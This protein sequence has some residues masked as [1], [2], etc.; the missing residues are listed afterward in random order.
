MIEADPTLLE[1]NL[2]SLRAKDPELALRIAM[3]AADPSVRAERARDGSVVPFAQSGKRQVY[4]NS[5]YEPRKEAERL[6]LERSG[7]GY[8]VCLGLGGGYQARAILENR[9]TSGVLIVETSLALLKA[10]LERIDIRDILSDG[11]VSVMAEA[12]AEECALKLSD[13]YLPVLSG[14]LRTLPL[15][16]RIDLDPK[17]FKAA[18]EMIEAAVERIAADFSVQSIF[19]KRWFSNSLMNLERSSGDLAEIG[20]RGKI[21][22]AAA[23]PSLEAQ[24]GAMKRAHDEGGFLLSTDTALPFLLASSIRPDAVISIDCQHI[25]YRH[26]TPG[27]PSCLPVI[28]ELSSP[29]VL[30][31]TSR[32]VA[33]FVTGNPLGIYLS[34]KLRS[35]PLLDASGG[36]VTHAAISLALA[37][38]AEEVRLYG[39]DYSYP[40]GKTYA[41]GTH[42][43]ASFMEEAGR[44]APLESRMADI[45]FRSRSLSREREKDF[46][47][48]RNPVL[49]S[50]RDAARALATRSNARIAQE[51]GEGLSIQAEGAEDSMGMGKTASRGGFSAG[52]LK[53]G[54]REVL[55]GFKDGIEALRL[56]EEPLLPS[57]R[58]A[59]GAETELW[60]ALL[61]LAA[62]ITRD[63]GITRPRDALARARLWALSRLG[64]YLQAWPAGNP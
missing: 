1:R 3:S 62:A 41:R 21:L 16:A 22:V 50:Y 29:P 39:A 19:G 4:F 37:L 33:F 64:D 8:C 24:A 9:G 6:A 30:S 63:E 13:S 10:T 27:C 26:F 20:A 49:D 46:I 51:A 40:R 42:L 38:G 56:P 31:R 17:G 60:L 28:M 61:P 25:S 36:N 52:P 58:S 11:R 57:I 35:L 7:D 44:L 5:R 23:G 12:S 55:L 14:G 32:N 54:A 48:Y 45:L 43:Y 2:S 53:A 18:M 34:R 47:R 59:G 15:R